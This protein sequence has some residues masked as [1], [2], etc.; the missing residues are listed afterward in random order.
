M[1]RSFLLAAAAVGLALRLAFGLGYWVNQTLTRDELEYLSLARS[2]ASGHGF[3]YD[4][5]IR[6]LPQEPFGRAPGYPLVLSL[7]GGGGAVATSTPA[8]VKI[9][10]AFAGAS[11]VWLVGVL[12]FRLAG[13]RAAKVA[14]AIA[15]CYPPLVWISAYA[16]SEVIFFPLGLAIVWLFDR[17]ATSDGRTW[18]RAIACGVYIGVA[19]LVRPATVMFLPLAAA[20]LIWRR[21]LPSAAALVLGAVIVVGPWTIRNYRHYGHFVLVATEGGV[22]FWTGNNPLARG[23]GDMAANPKLRE[24]SQA[25]KAQ[26]PGVD[27]EGM[28]PIYYRTALAWMRSTPIDWLVLEAKKAFFLVVPIGPSYRL[29][30]NLYF[31]GSVVPYGLV[32]PFAIAGIVRLGSRRARTPGLWLLA[33]S[34]V[35]TCL[36][37]FPQ[38]RFRIPILDPTLIVCAGA[39]WMSR[40][41]T[42]VT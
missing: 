2:I 30:S 38:E 24:A 13:A 18:P 12:A 5:A 7:I 15:A 34:A 4:D 20:W 16:L 42:S 23:D 3:V 8:T 32:L 36:M 19:V 35:A 33:G 22:T 11:G 26:H 10:Q 17:V 14:A 27:E 9:V 25:L 40:N 6:S 29:H 37:F 41:E 31:L 39:A 1:P 28:E 21:R